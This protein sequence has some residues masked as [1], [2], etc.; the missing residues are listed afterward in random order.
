VL[1]GLRKFWQ[2]YV[3]TWRAAPFPT[4]ASTVLLAMEVL[5]AP[6]F[7]I[8]SGLVV[9]AIPGAIAHGL[10]SSQGRGLLTLLLI[11]GAAQ[12]LVMLARAIC[13]FE[14][15]GME[16]GVA[17]VRRRMLLEMSLAPGGIAHLEDP[18][19][20]DQVAIAG[21]GGGLRP[22][23][24]PARMRNVVYAWSIPI[25]G[26]IILFRYLW[27]APLLLACAVWLLRRW[28]S[29]SIQLQFDAA[30]GGIQ[31]ARRAAYYRGLSLEGG[32]A[33]ELRVFDLGAFVVDRMVGHSMEALNEIWRRRTRVTW[34][35]VATVAAVIGSQAIVYVALGLS[36]L[37]G[38]LGLAGLAMSLQSVQS[39]I[40]WTTVEA[41][42][43][44][45]V[46]AAALEATRSLGERIGPASQIAGVKPADG[47]PRREIRLEG[48]RFRYPGASADVFSDLDLH[49]PAGRSTAIVGS[50]G[51]GKT[52]LIKLI[53]RLYNPSAGRITI[54][55]QDLASLEPEAWRR[56][57]AVVFQDFTTYEM[58]ARDNIAF[59]ALEVAS[60]PDALEVA[61]RQ[62]GASELIENLPRGWDT[63]L[64][65]AYTGGTDL[66][67]GQWQRVALARAL[68]A[69]RRGGVL[70]LD[71]PTASLDVRAEAEIFD[72]FLELTEGLT[73]ILISHRFSSV[74]HAERIVVIEEG[75]VVE[76]GTHEELL[77]SDGRYAAMFAM[78]ADR[79]R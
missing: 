45:Q 48:V 61:A 47:V 74:R 32:A 77:A 35:M 5:W 17:A 63:I 15:L 6:G 4:F 33:K 38:A 59:G 79:F 42:V 72:R 67:G 39:V 2:N 1:S 55:G 51:A 8:L 54:D 19:F 69:A 16:Q 36:A 50:N 18:A 49:I 29:S 68:L 21:G 14:L 27:W 37:H 34:L 58:S 20:G 24:M 66:S 56:R 11:A 53:A 52:T 71:E 7:T 26:A 73:T 28:E 25:G 9:G 12:G 60:A 76:Q 78:Q 75:G 13:Q 70:I 3:F 57:L 40:S 46:S 44:Y 30:P 10:G 31:E 41:Q 23:N 22:E 62:A 65:R 43:D 64:S